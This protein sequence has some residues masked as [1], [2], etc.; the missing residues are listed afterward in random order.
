MRIVRSPDDL[1]AALDG[2]HGTAFVPTMGNLHRGHLAL[3]GEAR[4]LGG[5]VVASV[6][7]NRLQFG[8][9]EDF[10]RYPRTLDDDAQALAAT[11][12]DLLYA[13]DEAAIYPHAQTVLVQ[14]PVE[15]AQLCGAHRPGHFAGVLTVVC[16]LFNMVQPAVAV[17]GEKDLQQLWLIRQMTTQL[18][19]P[20]RIV[21][22]P[23]ERDAD[24][25]ALSSRNRYL[26]DV[27]RAQA[28]QLFAALCGVR[29]AIRRGE[30]AEDAAMAAASG[31][32]DAGWEVDYVEVRDAHSLREPTPDT[33]TW[34]VLA[35]ARLG[36][37]RLI[38]NVVFD[39]GTGR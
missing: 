23:T 31:L 4:R 22:H 3:I 30:A 34:A 25:L 39:S 26:S 19:L 14:P 24:G 21:G 36:A 6:F 32:R 35:A 1:R 27:E 12:C 15:A 8:A 18:A 13:P 37:T 5:P 11:G 16:K 9:G 28:P 17:F 2:A 38:D 29:D 7:V 33:M 20:I 10:E